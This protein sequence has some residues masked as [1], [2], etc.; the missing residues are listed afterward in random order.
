MKLLTEK[1]I[2]FLLQ[3][4]LPKLIC[5]Y[6]AILF[7]YSFKHFGDQ[8]LFCFWAKS[9]VSDLRWWKKSIQLIAQWC[10]ILQKNVP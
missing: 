1:Y 2:I 8:Y 5:W 9:F 7:P 10:K 3:A 4:E 6:K